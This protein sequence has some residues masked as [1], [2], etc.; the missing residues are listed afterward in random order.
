MNCAIDFV[1]S[2]PR[3][4]Q[5]EEHDTLEEM[6]AAAPSS[7]DAHAIAADR[8]V[9]SAEIGQ[10]IRTAMA[11]L[12]PLERTAFVLRHFEG[13]SIDDISRALGVRQNAAKHCIFRAVRKMRV[14]LEAFVE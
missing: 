9:A 2:R 6:A 13:Q 3:R 10:R 5:A 8:L 12:S 1:R 11:R 7:R 14:A 4:E